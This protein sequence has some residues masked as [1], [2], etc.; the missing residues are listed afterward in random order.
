MEMQVLNPG[1]Q[2]SEQAQ[3]PVSIWVCGLPTTLD[4]IQKSE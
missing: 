1:D 2:Q 4:S 3:T